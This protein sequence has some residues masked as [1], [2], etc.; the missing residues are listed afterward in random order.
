MNRKP[1]P[2]PPQMRNG[3]L[4]PA[5]LLSSPH[6]D[7]VATIANL[8]AIVKA[9]ADEA[10]KRRRHEAATREKA[11][12]NANKQRCH[13]AAVQEKALAEDMRRQEEN[14]AIR[15][16]R[17]KC[18]LLAA[19]LEAILAKIERDNIAHETN[20]QQWAAAREKALANKANKQ[21][22]HKV[23]STCQEAAAARACMSN[24]IARA[25]QEDAHRQQLLNEQAAHACQEAAAACAR[26]ELEEAA[27][28]CCHHEA[29]AH[30]KA[31]AALSNTHSPLLF[32]F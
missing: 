24:A 17:I 14:A 3:G 5:H 28:K 6:S 31:L 26:Q 11:L 7:P 2:Y 9:L 4:P 16:I 10:N 13:K 22:C 32:Y 8:K 29:A 30:D 1:L 25:R 27:D 15:R 19:P 20:E 23:A 18:A 21:R 12:A